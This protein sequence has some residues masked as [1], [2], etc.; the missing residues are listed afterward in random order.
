MFGLEKNLLAMAGYYK[1]NMM[2]YK[3]P[4]IITKFNN[5]KNQTLWKHKK[6]LKKF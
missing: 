6:E 4:R 3:K 2:K 5:N 1:P